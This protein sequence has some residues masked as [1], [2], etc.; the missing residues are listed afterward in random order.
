M[1]EAFCS[2]ITLQTMTADYSVNSYQTE[3]E[4]GEY[5]KAMKV[6]EKIEN[7]IRPLLIGLLHSEKISQACVGFSWSLKKTLY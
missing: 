3:N 2:G 1:C 4:I 7:S 5:L 6:K